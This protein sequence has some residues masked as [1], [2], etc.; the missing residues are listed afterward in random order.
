MG[1]ALHLLYLRPLQEG[2]SKIVIEDKDLIERQSA[3]ES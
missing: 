1:Q 2:L 3:K